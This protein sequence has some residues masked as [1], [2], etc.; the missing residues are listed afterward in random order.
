MKK[1]LSEK[2]SKPEYKLEG[3]KRP[4]TV[5]GIVKGDVMFSG[6]DYADKAKD[7]KMKV[8][9]FCKAASTIVE[10]AENE[11]PF[12]EEQAA[13]S[14]RKFKE[15]NNTIEK[16]LEAGQNGA[17]TGQEST[18]TGEVEISAIRK[19]TVDSGAVSD[20]Q[21][22]ITVDM[23]D[24]GHRF[25]L[26]DVVGEVQIVKMTKGK[27]AYLS[28]KELQLDEKDRPDP[29]MIKK[30]EFCT[31]INT[32]LSGK[33]NA[34]ESKEAP[35]VKKQKEVEAELTVKKSSDK[36]QVD[37]TP[38]EV[39]AYYEKL[40]GLLEEMGAKE[41]EKAAYVSQIGG[42]IKELKAEIN[43]LTGKVNSK[44]EFREVPVTIEYHWKKN[45]KLTIRQ[46]TG[47]VVC[48]TAIPKSELQNTFIDD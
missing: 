48:E 31:A 30:E 13:E 9:D 2:D 14:D 24:V 6:Y 22:E 4:V 41:S 26:S 20:G 29:I 1:L 5:Q 36:L 46:D 28:I 45:K 11:L 25:T 32:Y 27:L 42:E 47:A 39:L 37:L 12:T 17:E 16:N 23:L 8:A 43:T 44:K 3:I 7:G 21:K 10:V 19:D 18:Q 38:E 40:S 33:A 15:L 34:P 35:K